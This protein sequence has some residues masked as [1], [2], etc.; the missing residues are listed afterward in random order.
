MIITYDYAYYNRGITYIR[1]K[2]YLHNALVDFYKAGVL[3]LENNIYNALLY[4]EA[5]RSIDH[6]SPLIDALLKKFNP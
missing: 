6:S 5:M 2:K 1:L 3:Y 4:V